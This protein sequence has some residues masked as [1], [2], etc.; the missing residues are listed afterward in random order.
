[1]KKDKITYAVILN[2]GKYIEKDSLNE[3][4]P[5]SSDAIFILKIEHDHE[6]VTGPGRKVNY[7]SFKPID[8]D[9]N[10]INIDFDQF[11]II[12][13]GPE[14]GSYY[15]YGINFKILDKKRDLIHNY[16]SSKNGLS[17]FE[18]ELFPLMA[19]LNDAGSWENY[20][21]GL[22]VKE[23]EDTIAGLVAWKDELLIRIKELESK[24]EKKEKL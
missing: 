18:N 22:K 4:K 2:K 1:M 24:L 7:F 16:K 21:N 5:L 12:D 13:I 15:D 9:G 8:L 10:F 17:V 3:L 19:K 6:Y 23:Q 20:S 11:R 14:E